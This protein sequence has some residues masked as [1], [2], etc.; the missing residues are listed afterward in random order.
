MIDIPFTEFAFAGTGRTTTRTM[1]DRLADVVNVK[2]F[3]ALGNGS[4]AT[5]AFQ[6]AFNTAV[7]NGK[8]VFI[9]DGDYLLTSAITFN[10]NED[11][12]LCVRGV[13]NGGT[14]SGGSYVHG[15]INNGYLFDR[16]LGTPNN[17]YGPRT[18]SDLRL[19]NNGTAGGCI[20]LGSTIG[21]AVRNCSFSA[22]GTSITTEDAAGAS[23]E[24]IMVES[25]ILVGNSSVSCG[26][27]LGGSGCIVGCDATGMDTA[28]VVYGGGSAIYGTRCERNNSALKLGVDSGGTDRGLKGFIINGM[29]MEGNRHGVRFLGT[30]SGFKFAGISI[31]GHDAT[32]SGREGDNHNTEYAFYLPANKVF[33]GE[34]VGCLSDQWFDIAGLYIEDYTTRACVTFVGCQFSVGGGA[35]VPWRLSTTPGGFKFIECDVDA[36]QNAP[37]GIRYAYANLPTSTVLEGDIYDTYG[38][39]STIG[40]SVTST[41]AN[42]VRVRW[43]GTAWIC[44]GG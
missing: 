38:N 17:T 14:T 12:G 20:R 7:A 25:C 22:T 2:E 29:P 41:G 15:A 9:P 8:D 16:S 36:S 28:F 26:V 37:D 31:T 23:S 40:N 42:R 39:T 21:G 43:N 34:L 4:N 10:A 30:V 32:N 6:S 44:I 27:V 19:V 5:T 24:A 33:A 11:F 35:G 18:F 1:P 3:G 13:G